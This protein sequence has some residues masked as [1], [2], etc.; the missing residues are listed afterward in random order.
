MC[1][2]LDCV[3]VGQDLK[4]RVVGGCERVRKQDSVCVGAN[5]TI[6]VMGVFERVRKHDFVYVFR[7]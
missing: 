2:S 1:E 6:R 7:E 4:I 3:C 5:L